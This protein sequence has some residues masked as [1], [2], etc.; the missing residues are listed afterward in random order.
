MSDWQPIETAPKPG[1]HLAIVGDEERVIAWG[2]TSHLPWVGWCLADQGVEDFD[3]CIP[4]M[5]KP[6]QGES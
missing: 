1:P 6:L 5:W 3:I 4:T 2:K